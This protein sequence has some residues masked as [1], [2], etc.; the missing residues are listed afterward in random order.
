[1]ADCMVLDAGADRQSQL[2]S[3]AESWL[4]AIDLDPGGQL[5]SYMG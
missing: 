1:M 5:C 2:I 3:L 4:Q